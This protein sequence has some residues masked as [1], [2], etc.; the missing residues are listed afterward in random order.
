MRCAPMWKVTPVYLGSM[1]VDRG[2]LVGEPGRRGEVAF[3][4]WLLSR[5]GFHVLVDTGPCSAE[6]ATAHHNP[7]TRSDGDR[8]VSRLAGHGVSPADVRLVINTHL[9][10]DHCY[11]NDLFPQARIVVQEAELRYAVWPLPKDRRYYEVDLGKF[12][13]LAGYQRIAALKGDRRLLPGLEVILT[14][15][16]T[17]GSQTVLVE[18]AGGI[19]ALPGDLVPLFESVVPEQLLLRPSLIYDSLEDYYCSFARIVDR[20]DFLIPSHDPAL[21]N[22]PQRSIPLRRGEERA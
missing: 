12:P 1:V 22:C 5:D 18:T 6:E 3:W 10:W 21:L 13:F 9:H 14:P 20:A 2:M 11:G 16:H 17:P 4:A 19:C 8:L 15:G 7:T